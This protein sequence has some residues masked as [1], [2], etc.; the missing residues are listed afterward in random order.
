MASDD[1]DAAMIDNPKLRLSQNV[2]P[3]ILRPLFEDVPLSSQDLGSIVEISCVE[4]WEVNLYVGT[5]IGEILH[6]V[7][8]PPDP[9][10]L[11]SNP[12]YILASRLQPPVATG[13]SIS[14]S[15]PGIQ[16]IQLL[17]R[18]GKACVL[19]N[20]T[21]SFYSLPELTPAFGNT[22]I[23]QCSWVGGVDLNA[24]SQDRRNGSGEIVMISV[25]KGIRLVSIGGDARKK[26]DIMYAGSLMSMR[27]G[28]VSC[29]ADTHTYALLDVE[30]Q[31]KIPLFPISSL[32]TSNVGK[33]GGRVEDIPSGRAVSKSFSSGRPAFLN[34][35]EE[36]GHSRSTSLGTIV[37]ALSRRQ[38]SPL[39][40]SSDRNAMENPEAASPE[41]SADPSNEDKKSTSIQ[42]QPGLTTDKALPDP[43]KDDLP[44]QTPSASM[45]TTEAPL[46]RPHI[47]SPTYNEFLLTTGTRPG[48]PGVGLLINLDGDVSRSTLEFSEYPDWIVVDGRGVGTEIT[49]ENADESEEGYVLATMRRSSKSEELGIEVQRWDVDNGDRGAEKEWINVPA[50]P[51]TE[52]FNLGIR[53]MVG[54]G[55]I[56]INELVEKLC[57]VRL[58]LGVS[59]SAESTPASVESF[60]SR[61]RTSIERVSGEMELFEAPMSAE[62]GI[63]RTG[64]EDITEKGW[65]NIR[66]RE[67]EDFAR[68]L[69]KLNGK[70]V[71]WSKNQLWWLL[72]NPLAIRL[73]AQLD[74]YGGTGAALDRRK[75]LQV[76]ES[77]RE[78]EGKTETEYISLVYIRQKIG[79]LLLTD[80][81]STAASNAE[82][83][84]SFRRAT[85]EALLVGNVDPRIVLALFPALDEEI[86]EGP[87]GIW[88][89]GG[90]KGV[91]QNFNRH[92]HA[93]HH[94]LGQLSGEI[95]ILVKKYLSTWRQKKGFGSVDN[96]KEVFYTVD[97]ALL[98][99]LLELDKQGYPSS[100]GLPSVRS[101]LYA[102]VDQ[103]MEC[104]GRGVAMLEQC[105]RL[106]V[107]SRLYQS[108]KMSREVLATWKRIL[109]G[110]EAGVPEFTNGEVKMREYLARLK[111]VELVKEYG[112]WLAQRNPGLGVQVFTD[113]K[114]R[115]RF[116]PADVVSMLKSQAPN[117]VKDYLEH[118]VFGKNN[119]QY[120]NDLINFYLDN[121]LST[122]ERSES[123]RS[124]LTRSYETYRALRP[125]KPTYSQFISHN[126]ID[127]EWWGSR[128]R[129]L[130]LLGGSHSAVSDFDLPAIAARIQAHEKELIP[131]M[132]ILD[133]RRS[134]HPRALRLLTHGL[135]DYDTAFN[136]CL[137]G[138]QG[139]FHPSAGEGRGEG[140]AGRGEQA[141]LF[142]QLLGELLQLKDTGEQIEQTGQLLDRFGGWLDVDHVLRLIPDS[143][144]IELVSRF[145]TGVL[146]RL[147]RERRMT[148]VA[149]ALSGAE[150]LQVSG[151]FI[152]RCDELG[153]VLIAMQ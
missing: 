25:R 19:C 135:G 113:E 59:G 94:Q 125:P 43:P 56:H 7:L 4:V 111:D 36:K 106:Y 1:D 62:A 108:R 153:G 48:E 103:G 60:D 76:A 73:D 123:A 97:A 86:I 31:R 55:E 115:V 127:E 61:T 88:T 64:N 41:S 54:Q 23:T 65:E 92:Q 27:R 46:L 75:V 138:G 95:L 6:F 91:V 145:F 134:L 80:L 102:L 2:G 28:L 81:I 128:I 132:I 39:L 98:R 79:L 17:P 69:G 32:D 99:V 144:S 101:E 50:A 152:R 13:P 84:E 107:L 15:R 63:T 110:S 70:I 14:F 66:L 83:S 126:A 85:E 77:I 45:P 3:Y 8:I 12:T 151:E 57:R 109:E 140:L 130:Q 100:P 58:R 67:E 87:R 21:L 141:V 148:M 74:I 116:V 129:L 117:A 105:K 68:R 121:V 143:W 90:V 10:D 40:D 35:S 124:T 136:Y 11:S 24:I 51:K 78:Q 18:V 33:V 146:R 29:V 118:L 96:E 89:Y 42:T 142:N 5:S 150:N 139:I 53:K 49:S 122:L 114:S 71:I 37:G 137:W 47:L 44:A 82:I 147:V 34:L 16:Q 38:P 120:A 93:N 52:K 119:V 131:E 20:G 26:Q 133:G 112:T 104:F 72:R 9:A 149:K 30:H 22:K